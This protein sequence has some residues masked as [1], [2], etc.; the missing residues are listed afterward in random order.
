MAEHKPVSRRRLLGGGVLASAAAAYAFLPG[1]GPAQW[2]FAPASAQTAD[3][4]VE[5]ADMVLGAADAPIEV[6]EYSSFTCPHCAK[7][8]KDVYPLLKANFIDTGKIRLVYREVFF[9]RPGLW[10][11]MIARCGGPERFFGVTELIFKRQS[12]WARLED[13]ESMVDALLAIGRQ[14]GLDEAAMQDCIRD[15]A[16]ARALYANFKEK[17]T[18]HDINS[19]PSFII[20]GK[21]MGNMRYREFERVLNAIQDG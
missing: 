20:N 5:I 18:Y 3:A 7:F 6:I 17:T 9:D 19:T 14:A 2:L 12:E 4:A 10:A 8:H 11:A 15:E 16:L 13:A 1:T 21:K